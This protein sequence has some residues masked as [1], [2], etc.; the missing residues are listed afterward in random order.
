MTDPTK[1]NFVCGF[2][3]PGEDGRNGYFPPAK[4]YVHQEGFSDVFKGEEDRVKQFLRDY[5]KSQ[6]E[7]TDMDPLDWMMGIVWGDAFGNSRIDSFGYKLSRRN[8]KS[9]PNVQAEATLR[10]KEGEG[11]DLLETGFDSLNP[12]SCGDGLLVLGTEERARRRTQDIKEYMARDVYLEFP[13]GFGPRGWRTVT[14]T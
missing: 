3:I 13:E 5:K 9:N 1:P 12:V 14:N 4:F 11:F 2:T 6:R 7:R 8:W 10:V